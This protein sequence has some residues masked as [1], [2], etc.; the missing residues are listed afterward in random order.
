MSPVDGSPMWVVVDAGFE[1]QPDASAYLASLRG[2][3]DASVNTERTYAGR[4]AFYLSYCADRGIDWVAPS[5]GQLSAFLNWLVGEPWSSA[6]GARAGPA[7]VPDEGHRERHH[8]HGLQVPALLL[9]SRRQPRVA[10][11]GGSSV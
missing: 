2:Q 1:L 9:A 8:G 6:R 10:R 5:A 4:I 3:E 11:C 7:E